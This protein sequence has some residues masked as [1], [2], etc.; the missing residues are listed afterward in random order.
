[1]LN[2]SL[3]KSVGLFFPRLVQRDLFQRSLFLFSKSDHITNH[4]HFNRIFKCVQFLLIFKVRLVTFGEP[5]TGNVAFAKEM[6][7]HVPFRYRVVK[8]NDAVGFTSLHRISLLNCKY[9]TDIFCFYFSEQHCL[10]VCIFP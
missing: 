4:C 6:E 10:N 3:S 8:K 7:K 9:L 5:R 2:D 1:M